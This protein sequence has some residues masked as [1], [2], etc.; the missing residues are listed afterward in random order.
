MRNSRGKATTQKTRNIWR[1]DAKAR[2]K[3]VV[4]SN[5][6]RNLCSDPSHL[7]GMT[8]LSAC[9]SASWQENNPRHP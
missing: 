3:N 2:R 6:E 1:K 7:L 4:I 9:H 8:G 5:E